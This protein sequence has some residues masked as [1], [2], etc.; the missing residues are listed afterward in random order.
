MRVGG[1]DPNFNIVQSLFERAG[2]RAPPPL[3]PRSSTS[4]ALRWRAFMS[5]HLRI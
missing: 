2:L 4:P 1:G 3:T 5:V